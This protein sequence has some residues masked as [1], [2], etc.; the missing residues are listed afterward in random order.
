MSVNDYFEGIKQTA[1][2][3]GEEDLR[4]PI[5]YR[6]LRSFG[7]FM[8][9]PI[10]RIIDILP[11]ARMNPYRVTPWHCIVTITASEYKDSDIG[12]NNQVSIGVPFIMDR[13]SP[14][15]TGILRRPPE[16]PM[17]YLLHLQANTRI[18]CSA[19]SEM[20]DSPV[21]LSDISF[22]DDGEWV[23]CSAVS[24]GKLILRLSGR[25]LA[26]APCGRERVYPVTLKQNRL[27]RSD[28][29]F[30]ECE[31]GISKSRSDVR[32]ELGDHPAGKILKD[33]GQGRILLYQYWP[34]RQAVLSMVCE[35]YPVEA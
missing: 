19:G 11:S 32:L 16:F 21:L 24:D 1:A 25:K 3:F 10:D 6:S 14:V 9:A 35:S 22:T 8:L 18:S 15:L 4:V 20:A 28:F 29:S 23:R 7:I 5:F 34:S 2:R 27:L 13:K 12:P 30:S 33:L 26:V 31:A 17:I